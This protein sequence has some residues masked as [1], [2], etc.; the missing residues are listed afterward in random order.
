MKLV[1]TIQFDS[2]EAMD[3]KFIIESC[4]MATSF[5]EP[6]KCG[7]DLSEEKGGL[8]KVYWI[9]QGHALTADHLRKI[10]E[11]VWVAYKNVKAREPH[12]FFL[13]ETKKQYMEN[14]MAVLAKVDEWGMMVA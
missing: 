2:D 6:P 13:E 7:P 11:A 1:K 5:F 3:I 9:R 14:L 4:N 12:Q 8:Q 10:R